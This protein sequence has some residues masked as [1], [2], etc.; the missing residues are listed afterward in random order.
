MINFE[1][2]NGLVIRFLAREH[3]WADLTEVELVG[4]LKGALHLCGE[5]PGGLYLRTLKRLYRHAASRL[6]PST[7]TNL[8]RLR[9][10]TATVY[11]LPAMLC[12]IDSQVVMTATLNCMH[13]A[14]SSRKTLDEL[15]T[16]LTAHLL[17]RDARNC[18]ALLAGIMLH[19]DLDQ[20]KALAPLRTHLSEPCIAEAARLIAGTGSIPLFTFWLDW[21]SKLVGSNSPDDRRKFGFVMQALKRIGKLRVDGRMYSFVL[22]PRPIDGRITARTTAQ[23]DCVSFAR[24]I[25]GPLRRIERQETPPIRSPAVMLTWGLVP[26]SDPIT[27]QSPELSQR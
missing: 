15:V 16:C 26:E 8:I 27:T 24:R 21:A 1:S 18:G 11:Y 9:C 19:S 25:E 10:G 7:R 13:S 14:S 4:L 23:I 6:P 17:A 20:L 3:S 12:D 22:E 2:S 5:Q